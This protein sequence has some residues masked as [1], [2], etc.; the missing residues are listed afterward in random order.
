M[1]RAFSSMSSALRSFFKSSQASQKRMFSS[2]YSPRK[3]VR[4]IFL[5][6]AKENGGG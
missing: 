1:I 6:S 4:N 5:P 2:E 3:N